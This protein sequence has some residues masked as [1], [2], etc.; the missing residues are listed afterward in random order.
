MVVSLLFA[1]LTADCR[2]GS[3]RIGGGQVAQQATTQVI[4]I[5]KNVKHRFHLF[6]RRH[7]K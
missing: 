2:D 5:A 3:C 4:Q 1:L 7:C 6:P